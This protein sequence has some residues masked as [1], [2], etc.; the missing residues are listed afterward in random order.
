[1]KTVQSFLMLVFLA[2]TGTRP[3]IAQWEQT[4]GPYGGWVHSI[5]VNDS[6]VF[7]GVY[8][9]GVYRTTNNGTNWTSI[10]PT[11]NQYYVVTKGSYLFAGGGGVSRSSD[12][13]ASWTDSSSP[14]VGLTCLITNGTNL[15]AG[16]ANSGV[17]RST[18][19]GIH[20]TT[21]NSGL[22]NH[23]ILCL[24]AGGTNLF[25]G[26]YD[27]GMFRSTDNG[28]TWSAA[29]SGL[30]S[31]WIYAIAANATNVFVS[32]S[33]SVYRSIDSG[34]SWSVTNN[35]PL[36]GAG[37]LILSGSNLYSGSLGISVSTDYGSSWTDISPRNLVSS[38]VFSL[39]V[40]G[41]TLYAGTN[42]SGVFRSTDNGQS[43]AMVNTGITGVVTRAFAVTD[44]A[45]FAGTDG[46]V[47][48]STDR[49]ASWIAVDSGLSGAGGVLSLAASGGN[50][51]AGC[52]RGIY[53]STD[54][55]TSWNKKR[56]N[57]A[58]SL[59]VRGTDIFAGTNGIIH[60]TD[61]GTTWTAADSG[62]NTNVVSSI[63]AS[64]TNLFAGTY[65]GVFR[66]SDNG[67]SWAAVN[68]GLTDTLVSCL[69]ERGPYL[70]AG[71]NAKG[72]FRSTDSGA[73]WTAADSGSCSNCSVLAFG[74][75]DT[76]ILA[77]TTLNA[78]IVSTDNGVSWKAIDNGLE[79]ATVF[80][81]AVWTLPAVQG[82]NQ[83]GKVASSTDAGLFAG[84]TAAD[85]L[86]RC[87]WRSTLSN[88]N[89]GGPTDITS[90][91]VTSGIPKEFALDQNYPNP[92]NPTTTI[93]Y[94]IPKPSYVVL[95]VYDILGRKVAT[96]VDAG[97]AP[98]HYRA[99]FD[100][101]K[102]PSGVYFYR[103]EAGTYHNTKKLLLLK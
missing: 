80:A 39:A 98:G 29:D 52:G 16:T 53:L 28:D 12:N 45:L 48:C 2:L 93:D 61:N 32:S 46:G 65:N 26:A 70:F 21:I 7:A 90:E 18:D 31:P 30:S 97:K 59:F 20:W 79:G 22:T 11:Q 19:D 63:V 101:T 14:N 49:G 68:T 89:L 40:S 92:F 95:S 102:L 1:M 23:N 25:A 35:P 55:G 81:I 13:G 100:A 94:D 54:N 6:N 56:N 73:T 72:I 57:T 4:N 69:A 27:G 96:L 3:G 78:V 24:A 66:S 77:S 33:G 91:H 67:A 83:L 8:P 34:A 71:T 84:A 9:G 41:D 44:S 99:T 51:F 64:G 50:L 36:T 87:V 74:V 37:V 103:F 88:W 43:W 82:K 5:A 15:Y 76:L 75:F 42:G 38:S 47:Y 17:Y 10:S 85:S 86:T 60:S 58:F 62:L